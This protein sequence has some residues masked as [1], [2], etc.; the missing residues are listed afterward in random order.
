MCIDKI[1]ILEV[2]R[3]SFWG[4][5]PLDEAVVNKNK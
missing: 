3:E 1:L 4:K 5:T 2:K